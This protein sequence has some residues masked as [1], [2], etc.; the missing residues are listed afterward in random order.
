MSVIIQYC[1]TGKG[2]SIFKN[3]ALWPQKIDTEVQDS[4]LMQLLKGFNLC[5][6]YKL[7]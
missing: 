7:L 6:N 3:C 5:E 2:A 4:A 1:L